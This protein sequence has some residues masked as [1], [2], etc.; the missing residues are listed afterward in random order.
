[1]FN[2]KYEI[3]SMS[4]FFIPY[5]QNIDYLLV[6]TS[7]LSRDTLDNFYLSYGE[8]DVKTMILQ[9]SYKEIMSMM[10]ISDQE[11]ILLEDK[12]LKPKVVHHGY[13]YKW[14][15]GDDA[16]LYVWKYLNIL[17][18]MDFWHTLYDKVSVC[19]NLL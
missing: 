6:F 16:F 3:L 2:N 17:S 14:N 5:Y 8:G 12:H 1:M 13:F 19:S 7:G 11:M 9:L 10:K 15:A 4:D 18:D